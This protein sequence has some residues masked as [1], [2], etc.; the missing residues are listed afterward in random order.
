MTDHL[1]QAVQ[2]IKAGNKKRARSILVEILK[3]EPANDTAWLWM[4]AVVDTDNLRQECL[5]E[6]LK[7]NPRSKKAEDALQ[8]LHARKRGRA[9][10]PTPKPRRPRPKIDFLV[11]ITSVAGLIMLGLSIGLYFEN[12]SYDAEGQDTVAAVV[13]T[14]RVRSCY[15][16]Y[17]FTANGSR[18][19][20]SDQVSCYETS[21]FKRTGQVHIDYLASEPQKSRVYRPGAILRDAQK[22]F[23]L[24]IGMAALFLIVPGLTLVRFLSI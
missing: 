22:A 17:Q 19:D 21:E 6:A 12:R 18:Y 16:D 24:G 14:R 15:V 2:Y 1:K 4:T 3:E 23:W 13:E 8:K 9:T 20:G 11:I 7:H 10:R 5:E